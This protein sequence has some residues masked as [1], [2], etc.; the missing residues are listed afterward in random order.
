MFKSYLL[1][2]GWSN[3]GMDK[4][5]C[6]VQ[7]WKLLTPY[8]L[9]IFTHFKEYLLSFMALFIFKLEDMGIYQFI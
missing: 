9:A 6:T 1:C 5:K 4:S 2:I 3:K 7:L 8:I